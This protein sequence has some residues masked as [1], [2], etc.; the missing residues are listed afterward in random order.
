MISGIPQGS[1]LGPL[2]FILFIWDLKLS[3]EDLKDPKIRSRILKY[4]D[5]SKLIGK[6]D[7]EEDVEYLQEQLNH[8]Y[9]WEGANIM[10][11]NGSKFQCVRLG[12][13]KVKE[14]TYIFTPDYNDPIEEVPHAKDLGI[15]ID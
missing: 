5:D 12:P 6:I 7:T 13:E 4:I 8:I 14:N 15:L 2:L 11:W 3:H 10:R 9:R 1:V